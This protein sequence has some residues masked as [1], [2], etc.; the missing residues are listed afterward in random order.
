MGT[1]DHT[2]HTVRLLLVE[3][4]PMIGEAIRAGLKRE[5]FT[6]DWV[7]D[8]EAAGQVLTH[9]PFEL[10]LLD[11]GLPGSDGLTL[12]KSLRAKHVSLPVLIITAR[13]AVSDRV[14]GL[15]AGADDYLIKPFDLDELAARIRALLRRKSGR[16][17][18]SVT[19]LNVVLEPAAHRVTQDGVEVSLS[20]REFALL[21]LLLERPGTI[22]SRAQIEERL[23]G[24]G[25]E[26]ESNAVEVH[27]HGLR[28]KLGAQF[29]LTVRG[30]GYRVRPQ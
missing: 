19:H 11:L 17:A 14:A 16:A 9:E 27:I 24:W 12:L 28:R 7:H 18:A 20:P 23:Y 13:D 5:G 8:G 15:D 26:V 21:E 2:L 6:I 1:I 30:V 22:L 29:I 25:E 10:V 3:D 4:D